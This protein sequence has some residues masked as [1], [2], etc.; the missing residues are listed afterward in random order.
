[1]KNKRSK[2]LRQ[3]EEGK[4]RRKE[5]RKGESEESQEWRNSMIER[6]EVKEV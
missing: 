6:R 3:V 4:D 1:M 2:E 5:Q